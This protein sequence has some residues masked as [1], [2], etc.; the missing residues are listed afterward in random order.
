MRKCGDLFV[1]IQIFH[2]LSSYVFTS[3]EVRFVEC[4]Y[5]Q[6]LR[7]LLPMR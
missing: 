3:I 1:K 6:T 7:P 2:V 5:P 4:E